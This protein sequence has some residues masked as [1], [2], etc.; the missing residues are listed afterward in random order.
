MSLE[1]LILAAAILASLCASAF[2]SGS[3]T[4]LL[5]ISRERIVHLVRKGS[6][7]AK[8]IQHILSDMG[9][10]TT[11]ILIGNN[12][13]NVSFSTASSALIF[14]MTT[15]PF[16]RSAAC[17][18]SACIVLYFGEFMPKLLFSARPLRRTLLIAP[19]FRMVAVILSPFVWIAM[20]LIDALMPRPK[21]ERRLT[22]AE[23]L[24]IIHDRRD[25]VRLSDFE[26][27]LITE[28]LSLR[29]KG[30]PVTKDKL[31]AALDLLDKPA[32]KSCQKPPAAM[33]IPVKQAAPIHCATT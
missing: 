29:S 32:V 1:I 10:A 7:R 13:A 5:S 2:F 12:L 6:K 25:G 11:T 27:V 18:L 20:K 14:A 8:T 30:K 17:F 23:I 31:F 26:H 15:D 3:E 33:K 4:G 19:V 22:T 16:A 9:R 24:G 21:A 28:L